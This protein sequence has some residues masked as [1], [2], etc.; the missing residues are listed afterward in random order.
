MIDR[1]VIATCFRATSGF[2]LVP[3]LAVIVLSFVSRSDTYVLLFA[4]LT[5]RTSRLG[6]RLVI[7]VFVSALA[8][9][10]AP[11]PDFR[12]PKIARPTRYQLDLTVVPSMP[13]F[14]G[15]EVIGI[16]L[17]EPSDIV[18]LNAKDLTIQEV[19]VTVGKIRRSVRW[20]LT[21]E[22]LAMMSGLIHAM[23][24]D[25]ELAAVLRSHL[26]SDHSAA[27]PIIARAA[28]RGEVPAGAEQALASIAHE[29]IEAQLF[30][31][32]RTPGSWPSTPT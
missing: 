32:M 7:G 14:Q 12:L 18:W 26:A 23:R 30:R 25:P 11:A 24:T 3:A 17:Q 5:R 27:L 6:M 31:Q 16:D 29:V 21:D 2:A 22:F 8:A 9:G 28:D 10:Q 19:D 20:R 13:S 4:M 15:Y 1:Q